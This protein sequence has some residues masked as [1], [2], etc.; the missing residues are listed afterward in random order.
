[1]GIKNLKIILTQKCSFAINERK[2]D[3]YRG[4]IFGIDISIF[5]YKY[6][7]NNDDHIE[8]LTRL[9]LRLLKNNIMPIFIFD[10]KPPKEKDG[11]LQNRR[12]KRDFLH[13]KK[14]I[15]ENCLELDRDNY[16]D[17]KDKILEYVKNKS[18]TYII[19]DTEIKSL[20]EKSKDEIK[21]DAEKVDKK[22]I[23]V[24]HHHISSAKKLF[25]L[26]GI[27][28]IQSPNE[29]ESLLAVLCKENLIDG[30]VS[31]DS[32]ILVNGGKLFIRNFNSE[33]NV[34]EEYCLEGILSGLKF[35]QDEF[36]DF[37]ILCGC[38]Y[39]EKIHGLG[40]V[41]SYKLI[42][43]YKNIEGV[44]EEIKKTGK[45]DIPENFDYSTARSLF[46]NPFDLN[47]VYPMKEKIKMVEPQLDA[48]KDFLK[49]TKLKEKYMKEIEKNLINYYLD[50]QQIQSENKI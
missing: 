47:V 4:M 7:Y 42:L 22:I 6:L 10:G 8:G 34:I 32:D 12:E 49:D 25:D 50:I 20:F 11:T 15:L 43:K 21:T 39:T 44:L 24:T 36:I 27:G 28:Y 13:I 18:D 48:L 30:C 33:K 19:D 17:F 9:I 14:D 2:L 3:N 31:E 1:M 45:Y 35:T 38:D 29:A 23:Y 5:L 41:T 16:D 40:P 37:C 26:F 46:K